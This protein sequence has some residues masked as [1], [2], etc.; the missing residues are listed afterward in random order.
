MEKWGKVGQDDR[1]GQ[2]EQ[3]LGRPLFFQFELSKMR[4]FSLK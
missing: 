1:S 3:S 2:E 4:I